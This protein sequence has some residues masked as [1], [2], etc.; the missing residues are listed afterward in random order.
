[1]HQVLHRAD[2][3]PHVCLSSPFTHGYLGQAFRMTHFVYF[4]E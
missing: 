1:M 2:P 4:N 3:E